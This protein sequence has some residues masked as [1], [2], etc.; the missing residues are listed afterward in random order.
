MRFSRASSVYTLHPTA[1]DKEA[2]ALAVKENKADIIAGVDL[3]AMDDVVADILIDLSQ[4]KAKEDAVEFANLL[5]PEM[6]KAGRLLRTSRREA[7]FAV[8]K[9]PDV[10][11]VLIEMGYLSNRQ[12]EQLLTS[13]AR[14]KK[15]VAAIARAIDRFFASREG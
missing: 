13:P 6:A 1:S 4:N 11:S 8:L 14:R 15:L 7:G 2:E 3:N 12:D 10:P 5:L 9:A